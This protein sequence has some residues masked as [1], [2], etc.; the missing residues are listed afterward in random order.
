MY[1]AQGLKALFEELKYK[2]Q[3]QRTYTHHILFLQRNLGELDKLSYDTIYNYFLGI[4]DKLSPNMRSS[5]LKSLRML[6]VAQ[7]NELYKELTCK[8][9]GIPVNHNSL[10]VM[11]KQEL[12]ATIEQKKPEDYSDPV[13]V[14]DYT[15]LM[16]LAR[17]GAKLGETIDLKFRDFYFNSERPYVQ[18]TNNFG[19]S[20]KIDL[21]KDLSD[22]APRALETLKESSIKSGIMNPEYIFTSSDK[23]CK[24]SESVMWHM[25]NDRFG[26]TSHVIRNLVLSEMQSEKTDPKIISRRLGIVKKRASRKYEFV[27]PA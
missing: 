2:K 7:G 11:S 10:Q 1:G 26:V 23:H 9:F 16:I 19:I 8:N 17:T 22:Y 25:L 18:V 21:S 20:R 5:A 14:R 4:K 13:E 3:T 27:Y 12:E 6:Y 24:I 15:L